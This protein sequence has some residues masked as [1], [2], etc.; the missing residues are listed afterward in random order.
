LF[1][2]GIFLVCAACVITVI[3]ILLISVFRRTS[4]IGTL[5]AIGASNIFISFIVIQEN[6]ILALIA[7]I[8]G[9]TG[10][11]FFIKFGCGL[12]GG[13]GLGFNPP[14]PPPPP[15]IPKTHQNRAKLN[16]IVKNV[17]NC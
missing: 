6:F 16:P 4:E 10:G 9:I 14:P 2:F 13:G 1:N 12:P 3:N 5:R 11:L 7:A 15:E 17:K 8:A